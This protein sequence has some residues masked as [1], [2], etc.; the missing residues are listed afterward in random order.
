LEGKGSFFIL[1]IIVAIL[2]LTLA[3]LAG[4]LFFVAGTPQTNPE[5]VT[6][7]TEIKRPSE[8]EL[9]YKDLFTDKQYFNLKNEDSDK[10]SVIM[11]KMQLVYFKKVKG[12][13]STD[14]KINL[15]EGK[16]KEIIGTYFQKMTLDEVKL[17]ETKDRANKELT[18]LI[19]QLLTSNEKQKQNIVY[20]IVFNEW[21]YQ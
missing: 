13:K 4:Y 20:E 16:I 1:L 15:N 19:N 21:F 11:V 10:T 6:E 8:S 17:P 18:G 7:K 5:A 14:E 2:T 9:A 12:I 3:V